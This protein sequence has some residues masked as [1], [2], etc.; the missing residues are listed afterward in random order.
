MFR[1]LPISLSLAAIL[2]TALSTFAPAS[3]SAHPPA[4]RPPDFGPNVLFVVGV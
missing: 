3:A 1:P 2:L 4:P